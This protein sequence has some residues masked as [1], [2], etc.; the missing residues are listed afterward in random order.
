MQSDRFFGGAADAFSVAAQHATR[1]LNYPGRYCQHVPV[2]YTLAANSDA[3]AGPFNWLPLPR[4][5]FNVTPGTLPWSRWHSTDPHTREKAHA[6]IVAHLPQLMESYAPHAP[7]APLTP[8]ACGPRSSHDAC[9]PLGGAELICAAPTQRLFPSEVVFLA[10][11][12]RNGV[13]LASVP[14]LIDKRLAQWPASMPA[15]H[16]DSRP[17]S[18][19]SSP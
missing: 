18:G 11:M 9:A 17:R 14:T 12:L 15:S 10:D 6:A 4:V 8:T 19:S 2:N 7:L 3:N 5:P 1:S 16:V 13:R